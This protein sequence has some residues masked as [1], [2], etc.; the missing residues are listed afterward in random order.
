[1]VEDICIVI[2]EDDPFARNWMAL[3]AARD[4]RTRVVGEADD[5]SGLIP[6]LKKNISRIGLILLDTDIPGGENWIPRIISS[7]NSTQRSPKILCT[8]IKPNVKVL[9]QLDHPSFCGYILKDEIVNSVAW[10]IA[11]AV[12]KNWVITDSI[13]ALASSIGFS[14]PRPCIVLEGRYAIQ[15]LTK[16][17]ANVARL[18]FLFSMERRN[19]AD[20]LGVTEDWSYGLVSAVYEKIGLKDILAENIDL[21]DYF[22]NH[23]LILSSFERIKSESEGSGKTHDMETLAFHLLTMPEMKELH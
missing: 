17:Q 5:P 14:L 10:A 3:L 2:V 13:Q 15:N 20:E 21:R 6:I 23:E 12:A 22:G 11:L 16:H 8:G 1:L 18:A 9:L 7:L 4:W 19:L